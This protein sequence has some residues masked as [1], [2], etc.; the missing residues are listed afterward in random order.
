[1]SGALPG[2]THKAAAQ[3]Y[4]IGTILTFA[5]NFCPR[6]FAP[7][8]GRLLPIAQYT[9]LFSLIGTTY[10]GD[11]RTTLGLP[12]LNGRLGMG[13]GR[14]P[15]L[16]N[17]VMGSLQGQTSVTLTQNNLAPHTHAVNATNLDGDKAGPGDKLLAAARRGGVGDETIYS[18]QAPNVEMSTQMITATG[19]SQPLPTL[20]PFL[21]MTR[22]IALDGLYP[23]RS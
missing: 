9:A 21:V 13:Q 23:S 10:G 14:G 18:E 4:F 2:A 5:G 12:N 6:N 22:C 3:E 17:R 7:A 11:G 20:D 15:G 1:M 16:T 8:D 19:G